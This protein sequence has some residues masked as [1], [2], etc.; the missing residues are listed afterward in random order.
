VRRQTD[1]MLEFASR[2][3]ELSPAAVALERSPVFDSMHGWLASTGAMP[4]IGDEPE[5]P[6]KPK[7]K[8]KVR[9]DV[10]GEVREA[11]VPS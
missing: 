10:G 7:R 5:E 11:L 9:V 4:M 6:P 8:A 1:E 2:A 3:P